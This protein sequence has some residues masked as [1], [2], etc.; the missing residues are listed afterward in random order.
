MPNNVEPYFDDNTTG[1]NEESNPEDAEQTIQ[2]SKDNEIQSAQ[3]LAIPQ[4]SIHQHVQLQKKSINK[5]RYQ[6]PSNKM[7]RHNT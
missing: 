1:Q 5:L 7:Q 4:D 2:F 6:K 3:T